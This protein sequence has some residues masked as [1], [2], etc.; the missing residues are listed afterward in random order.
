VSSLLPSRNLGQRLGT[1]ETASC[2]PATT[3]KQWEANDIEAHS[4]ASR[5][6]SAQTLA[7]IVA[8]RDRTAGESDSED[9]VSL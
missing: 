8:V 1:P 9:S 6:Y 4:S 7:C 3:S 5:N 2:P